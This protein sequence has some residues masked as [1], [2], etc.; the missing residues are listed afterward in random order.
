MPG[1][2]TGAKKKPIPASST[3]RATPSAGSSMTTPSAS[4]TSAAPD[5]DDAARPP[6]LATG[7]PA[8]AATTAAIVEMF[9]VWAPSPP[10]PTMSTQS[11]DS[12][13]GVAWASI[14]VAR[15]AT[16]SADSPFAR[17]ATAN[18]ATCT[19]V[20]SP[21]MISRIAH[22]VSA[23]ERSCRA[24]RRLSRPGHVG[25]PAGGA[26][27][28]GSPADD[29]ALRVG[30]QQLRHD[31]GGGERVDRQGQ[32]A[33]RP[34]PVR[35]PAV[36]LPGDEHADGRPVDDL[37]VQRAGDRQAPGGLGLPVEDAEVHPA[38]VDGGYDL[39]PRRAL[40]PGHRAHVG[41][42]TPADRRPDGVA[43]LG[44]VAV[45]Q[46]GGRCR[47][48]SGGLG[49]GAHAPEPSGRAGQIPEQLRYR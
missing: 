43:D 37:L 40:Q 32:R 12:R 3:H 21:V 49:D 14:S 39:V 28:G 48:M 9:T 42:G 2:N 10:V 16:S 17:R 4:S 25:R 36:G 20:A 47:G 34:G 31:A 6:C 13:T 46:H 38:G 33:L 19:G 18:A 44:A 29:G 30:A 8:A 24:S 35:Q 1:W 41:G 5:D 45:D 15:P 22:V 11:R 23:A 27:I 26:L 7:T